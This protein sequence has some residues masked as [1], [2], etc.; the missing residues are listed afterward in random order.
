MSDQ[1]TPVRDGKGLLPLEERHF[2]RLG[3]LVIGVGIRGVSYL[4]SIGAVG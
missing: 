4:G 3:W 1:V 2:L